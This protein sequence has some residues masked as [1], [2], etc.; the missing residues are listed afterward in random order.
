M[1]SVYMCLVHDM[2]EAI[3]GDI[4]PSDGVTRG[5]IQRHTLGTSFLT[6]TN[7]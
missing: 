6:A 1:K 2:G 4:T 5:S 3:I 7:M